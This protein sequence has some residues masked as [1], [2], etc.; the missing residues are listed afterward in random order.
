MT[1]PANGTFD[2]I[3]PAATPEGYRKAGFVSINYGNP[4]ALTLSR[5]MSNYSASAALVMLVNRTGS[6]VSTTLAVD[7]LCIRA[8]LFAK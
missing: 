6:A 4:A 8:D 3:I 2:C 7:I 5:M 1:V